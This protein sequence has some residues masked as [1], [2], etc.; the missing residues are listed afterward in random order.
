MYIMQEGVD[1][2]DPAYTK[3]FHDLEP[4]RI[5]P[6]SG[7]YR[8]LAAWT[9]IALD[10]PPCQ[11]FGFNNP[12]FPI[13]LPSYNTTAM[14]AAYDM[15]AAA[16][17]G[18]DNPWT[19]SIFMFEDYATSGVRAAGRRDS[20][21]FAF[22]EDL[23]LAAPLI[24]Y[25]STGA[26]EDARVKDLGNRLREIIK[27][28]TG[29]QELHAYVNYAY[30]DEGVPAWF[31]AEEWRGDRLRALKKKYDPTGVFSFYAPIV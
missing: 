5:T 18:A 10:S 28:G 16:I 29:R 2:V 3:P 31:G 8:D 14:R 23:L 17:R 13:Y 21:A 6:Q 12:R 24:I 9:G 26:D 25:N 27:E 15:Y 30:G 7:D 20:T 22:R 11:D 1:S 4:L 19:N